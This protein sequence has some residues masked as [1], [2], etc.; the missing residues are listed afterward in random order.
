MTKT[1]YRSIFAFILTLGFITGC[2][3]TTSPT[4]GTTQTE[5]SMTAMVNG[6]AWAS[7]G[8]PLVNGGALAEFNTPSAGNITITGTSGSLSGIQTIGIL[9][10]KPHLGADSLGTGNTGTFTYGTNAK[11]SYLTVGFNTGSVNITKYDTVNRLIS[12]TF[13]FVAHQIDTPAHTITVT[14]GSFLDVGWSK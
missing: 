6:S 5:S 13:S 9:L 7:T 8:V 14:N 2:N 12:G 1:N 11:S 10:L 3:A 4:T